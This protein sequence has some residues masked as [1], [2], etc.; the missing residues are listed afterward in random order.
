MKTNINVIH[1]DKLIED[2]K[3]CT[4]WIITKIDDMITLLNNKLLGNR[5]TFLFA[6][7]IPL[8][9]LPYA[10]F[11]T[12][13]NEIK[14]II[15]VITLISQSWFQWWSLPSLQI[16][17]LKGDI[18]RDAKAET[19]HQALTHIANQ[20]DKIVNSNPQITDTQSKTKTNRN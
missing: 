5:F 2:E 19:D 3:K 10:L 6:F 7:T 18:K 8:I 1:P 20:V 4:H 17:Q 9:L 12:S 15:L 13:S 16:T 14:L 11:D